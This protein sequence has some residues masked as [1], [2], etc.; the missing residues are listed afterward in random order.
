MDLSS[1][2]TISVPF[3]SIIVSVVAVACV[4][5]A[6]FFY[7]VRLNRKVNILTPKFGFGGKNLSTVAIVAFL[8]GVVPLVTMLVSNS[9][10]IR[11][12]AADSKLVVLNTQILESSEDEVVV[13]FSVVPMESGIAWP[14]EN[15]SA[16]W[17][18]T[19]PTS[20]TFLE[21]DLDSQNPSYFTRVL[22]TGN[23]MVKVRVTGDNFEVEKIEQLSF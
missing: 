15:Y 11:R 13:G 17:E 10:E 9:T 21:Q 20:F 1:R 5:F 4:L 23:Y 12:Q 6:L 14:E 7:V 18:V 2:I 22:A 3:I 8:A 16:V 19:G